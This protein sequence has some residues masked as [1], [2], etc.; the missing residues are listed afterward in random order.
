MIEDFYFISD[1]VGA[2]NDAIRKMSPIRNLLF[3]QHLGRR[4]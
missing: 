2:F 4:N 1:D 3:Y